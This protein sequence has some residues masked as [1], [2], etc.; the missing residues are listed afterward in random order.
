M[1]NR[2]QFHWYQTW[3]GITLAGAG[4]LVL[5]VILL[6]AGTT[7][8][9]WWQIKHGQNPLAEIKSSG[10]TASGA[11]VASAQ[12]DRIKLEVDDSPFLGRERAPVTIVEF[13]DFK[14]PNSKAAAPIISQ[15]ASKYGAKIKII[16]RNFPAE[17]IYPGASVLSQVAYCAQKQNRFWPMQSLLYDSQDTLSAVL[18]L[19]DLQTL[20][21]RVGVNFAD[22]KTCV[23]SPEAV[24]KVKLDYFAGI[25]AGVRGTPTFFINGEKVEGVV[26][27]TAWEKLLDNLK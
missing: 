19:E 8:K 16:V 20:A 13:V 9:Y 22:L 7:A 6:I 2:Q 17:S 26:P 1:E 24:S 11:S 4:F 12:I 18:S 3:W 21:D 23:S 25:Q 5:T 14:C 15:V 27:M 10:F